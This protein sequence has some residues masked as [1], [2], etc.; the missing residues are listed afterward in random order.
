VTEETPYLTDEQI[1][2]LTPEERRELVVR[3]ARPLSDVLPH[4]SRVHLFRRLRLGITGLAALIL[5][6]WIVYLAVTLPGRHQVRTWTPLWVG[7]DAIE[8]VLLAATFVLGAQRRAI[9][10]L[11]AFATGVVLLCDAWFDLLT[12]TRHELWQAVL[13]AVLIEIPLAVILMTPAIR[14][15]RVVPALLWHTDPGT[16]FWQVR[17]PKPGPQ[18]EP[19]RTDPP[20]ST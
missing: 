7:F 16:R 3:L 14:V 1:E 11:T 20:A 15:L 13:L 10:L 12:S 17:L 6:P 19:V 5:V 2:Q 18:A 9:S 8:L 4:S